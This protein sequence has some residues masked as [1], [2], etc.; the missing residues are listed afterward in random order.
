MADNGTNSS[1]ISI[2]SVSESVAENGLVSSIEMNDS[3]EKEMKEN[4]GN[5]VKLKNVTRAVRNWR[6]C[7]GCGEK[8]DLQRPSMQLR[9]Y[10]CK[11]KKIYIQKNDRVCK[12]HA[13]Q[14]NWD[15]IN[16]KTASNF[17]GKMV[18][19]MVHFFMNTPSRNSHSQNDIGV[20]DIQFHQILNELGFPDTPNKK[21]KQI[22]E[23]VRLY[24]D[25]LRHGH[26]YQQMGRW[27]DIKRRTI[28]K[29]I[30]FGRD[31]LLR[32]FVPNH[33]GHECRNRQW[34]INHTTDL[35]RL[36]YCNNDEKKCVVVLDATYIYTCDTSNYSH[37]RK[38]F[39]G[40]KHRHLFKIMKMIAID[41]TMIDC[42]GPFP[43]NMNDATIVQKIFNKTSFNNILKANDII[44]VD[45]GFRD[46][47][48]F[49]KRKHFIV[50]MPEFIQK[51]KKGQL[52]VLQANRSRLVTKL[53]FTIEAANGRMKNKWG[54]F[55]KIIPSILTKNLMADYRIGAALL[56]VFGKPILC[57]KEDY[58]NIG[59][60]MLASV[61]TPNKLVR[62]IN[63][64][65]FQKT[66]KHFGSLEGRLD[67]PKLD[68]KQIQNISLGCYAIRQAIS[69]AAEHVKIHGY[70]KIS[71]LPDNYVYEHFGKICKKNRIVNPIFILASIKSRYRG[72]KMHDAYI[73][74]DAN[75]AGNKILHYCKCQHGQRT[76]GRCAHVIAI[77]WYFG[78]GRFKEFKDPASHLNDFFDITY[79]Q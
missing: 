21:E 73:L 70:F 53:R 72:Q 54:L 16:F 41:G 25:R 11:S 32:D 2:I 13:Q 50:K 10:I 28:G 59:Q 20:T 9:Q 35:A 60:Q 23:A 74:Y 56:N 12:Y 55:R 29:K 65:K 27:Y 7:L 79:L 58:L 76:V 24:M 66:R 71:V 26:T 33:L 78:F 62:V 6:K 4:G 8:K 14:Q 36:L 68:Q 75:D 38:I 18:D 44:L 57:E 51:G 47:A 45:R 17:S 77:I 42:Y 46:C 67:F 34:L 43:A 37:Q 3:E 69:Y 61:K 15:R 5:V 63:S 1:L 49:L 19:E 52:T 31:V 48:N 40:Q 39:S 64:E 30:K 22:I